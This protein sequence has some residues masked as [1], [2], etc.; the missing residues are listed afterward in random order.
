[1]SAL[2]A[3]G[4]VAVALGMLVLVE[5]I[6]RFDS[7]ARANGL[8]WLM[9]GDRDFALM[10]KWVFRVFLVGFAIVCLVLFFDRL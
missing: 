2:A 7:W 8:G 6:D 3:L 1:V 4:G 9:A 10:M 5:G